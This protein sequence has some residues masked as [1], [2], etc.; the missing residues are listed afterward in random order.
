MPDYSA[1]ANCI[2]ALSMD[3]VQRANSGHPGMPMGMA[4]VATVLF[5]D[6]LKFDPQAPQWPDRDRFV[7]SAGHGSMLLYSLLYLS[8]YPQMDIAQIKNFR[9]WGSITPGHPEYG[10]TPGVE[11]TT[12]PLGQGLA[13]AVGMALGERLENARFG[14]ALVNHRTYVIVGDGC[15]A[16]GI[17]HEAASLAGHLRLSKLIVLFDDNGIT[18][19]G[20]TGL[21]VS[22]DPLRRFDACG[23]N[24]TAVDGHDTE[25]IRAALQDAQQST[26]PVLIACK[27]VI[28]CG[29]PN[30]QGTSQVHGAPLGDDEIAAARKA[31]D[32]PEAPFVIPPELLAQWKKTGD[33]GRREHAQWQQRLAQAAPEIHARWRQ[34]RDKDYTAEVNTAIDTL[35]KQLAEATPGMATRKASEKTL[36]AIHGKV[37][38]LIGGSA[39]L[40]GSNNT[41]VSGQRVVVAGDASGDYV[42]YGV[43]EHAMAAAMNGLALH[44]A[45]PFGGTFLVFSDYC[46]PAMRLSA[47]MGLQVIY[48]MTHDSIGLGEDGPTHQP[49]EHLAALRAMPNLAVYRPADAVETAEC[50]QAALTDKTRPAVL[51]LSRQNTPPLR[52]QYDAENL[53]ARGA[54]LLSDS[55]PRQL[56]IMASGTEVAL[57]VQVARQLAA[58]Q[59]RAAVVSFPCWERFARQDAAYQQAVLGEVPRFAIE[60]AAGFG[61]ERYASG[62]EYVFAMAGFGASA[63]APELYANFGFAAG[64]LADKI[65][66]TMDG[67]AGDG[68]K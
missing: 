22:D 61:W 6:F 39:D 65:I 11:T 34:W 5:A 45:V 52:C 31:L 44:G 21:S 14:E 63:P 32:W 36:A 4:D 51:A 30:K 20:P 38:G 66:A 12:G 68:E 35:K 27:T 17:S 10:H 33:N 9:Q 50:W 67:R 53:S 19:D 29:A 41:K 46:R 43:R 16:E 25:A 55:P 47:L 1:L 64:V 49:I 2:R 40:S 7:L 26:K 56:T 13:T 60:A 62:M 24:T 58:A 23:W 54:Y 42:H 8:G 57:A 28:G 59:M 15:L 18:I 48:V 3:A 37:A